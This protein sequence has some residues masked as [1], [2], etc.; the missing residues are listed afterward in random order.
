MNFLPFFAKLALKS[1]KK[2]LKVWLR[3]RVLRLPGDR[4]TEIAKR[5]GV[6]PEVV[7]LV[8][9]AIINDALNAIEKEI[10]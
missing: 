9:D 7:K 1:A 3:D 8:N 10:G 2:P 6:T 5:L 4:V